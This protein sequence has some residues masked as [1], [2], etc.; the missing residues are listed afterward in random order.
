MK[1]VTKE[2]CHF[3]IRGGGHSRIAGS[4]NAD[5]GVTIDLVKLKF[6]EI[7]KDKKT[8][9]IGAGNVWGDVYKTLED[10]GLTVVGGRVSD[11]GVG[12]FTLGGEKQSASV[13]IS[14]SLQGASHFCR[15]D[16]DGLA[17]P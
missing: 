17:I 5:A 2:Q 7:A 11:V 6:V 10:H 13:A 15:T 4:S 8:V 16:T 14:S 3:A 1:A 12:G 9:R